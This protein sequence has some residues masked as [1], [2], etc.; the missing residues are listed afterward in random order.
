VISPIPPGPQKRT[1]LF[2]Q[3]YRQNRI[4]QSAAQGR[5]GGGSHAGE[6]TQILHF[7]IRSLKATAEKGDYLATLAAPGRY[8]RIGSDRLLVCFL[9]MCNG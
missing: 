6:P 5:G 2:S 3:S 9:L 4:L 1:L 8:V 7:N